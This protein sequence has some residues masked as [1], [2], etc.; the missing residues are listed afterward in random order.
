MESFEVWHSSYGVCQRV[1]LLRVTK[2]L[3]FFFSCKVDQDFWETK[4]VTQVLEWMVAAT[5]FK[6]GFVPIQIKNAVYCHVKSY[7]L[8]LVGSYT[9]IVPVVSF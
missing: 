3:V 8:S 9:N 5:R 4:T 2:F 6:P 1:H 7:D